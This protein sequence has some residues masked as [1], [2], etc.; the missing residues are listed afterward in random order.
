MECLNS[1]NAI[2]LDPTSPID[3]STHA[4]PA[5]EQRCSFVSPESTNSIKQNEFYCAVCNVASIY[6]ADRD[7]RCNKSG[8]SVASRNKKNTKFEI[9]QNVLED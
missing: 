3:V 5:K 8:A 4:T 2:F 9:V 7:S 6:D 1:I